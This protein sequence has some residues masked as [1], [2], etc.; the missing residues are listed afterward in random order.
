[1]TWKQ[2]AEKI[3]NLTDSQKNTDVTVYLEKTDEYLAV[4]HYMEVAEQDVLDS[5]HPYLS[6]EF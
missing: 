5:G 6:I 1:M 4:N 3:G 2:L